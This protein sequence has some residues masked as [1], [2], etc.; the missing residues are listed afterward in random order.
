MMKIKSSLI[1]TIL[2]LT[3]SLIGIQSLKNY[4]VSIDEKFH[5][6]N[7]LSQYNYLKSFFDKNYDENFT[8]K[9]QENIELS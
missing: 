6:E 1:I 9:I 5:R 8:N 2:F 3:V 7:G 4:G